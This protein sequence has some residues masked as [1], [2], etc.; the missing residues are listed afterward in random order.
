[1]QLSPQQTAVTVAAETQRVLLKAVA[2]STQVER[3]WYCLFE[4]CLLHL[5]REKQQHIRPQ[6]DFR[7][8]LP[9]ARESLSEE[10]SSS[11]GAASGGF[12][13]IEASSAINGRTERRAMTR[14]RT[15]PLSLEK[16]W[17]RPFTNDDN[18]STSGQEDGEIQQCD[19]SY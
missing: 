6:T 3:S 11:T 9:A 14:S 18:R 8:I 5:R 12:P 1:M 10:A 2:I 13:L 7:F 19:H 15:S 17:R 4:R 16:L